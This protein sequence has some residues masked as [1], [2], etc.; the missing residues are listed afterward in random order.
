MTERG[1]AVGCRVQDN[2]LVGNGHGGML[3]DT[4]PVGGRW[5]GNDDGSDW[6]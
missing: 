1:S 5:T 6:D 3:L 4:P 2:D